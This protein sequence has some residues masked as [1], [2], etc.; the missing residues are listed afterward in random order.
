M[1]GTQTHQLV[2]AGLH[3]ADGGAGHAQVLKALEEFAGARLG[4]G[5]QIISEPERNSLWDVTG[6]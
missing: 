2:P 4:D 3:H 6:L 5:D 1:S